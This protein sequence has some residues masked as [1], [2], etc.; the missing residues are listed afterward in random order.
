MVNAEPT[1]RNSAKRKHGEVNEYKRE[2]AARDVGSVGP[3]PATGTVTTLAVTQSPS[4]WLWSSVFPLETPRQDQP[5]PTASPWADGAESWLGPPAEPAGPPETRVARTPP[6]TS[7]GRPP[8]PGPASR[9][10]AREG[11]GGTEF[12]H[13]DRACT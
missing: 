3:G 1:Q 12:Q 4:L 2:R 9:T 7:P 10:S 11:P 5:Q 13:G 6:A 8:L